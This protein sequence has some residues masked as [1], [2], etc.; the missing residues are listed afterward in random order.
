[1]PKQV[2]ARD[3]ILSCRDA[4]DDVIVRLKGLNTSTED[5]FLA[6]GEKLQPVY[7]K[8]E[9][10]KSLALSLVSSITGEQ[11]EGIVENLKGFIA[12][13]YKNIGDINSDFE[14]NTHMLRDIDSFIGN[15]YKPIN[16]F[17]KITKT[18]RILSISTKIES[19]KIENNM[20]GFFNI[21]GDVERL[22]TDINSR[23]AEIKSD[24][25]DLMTSLSESLSVLESAGKNC[26]GKLEEIIKKTQATIDTVY[27]KNR[28]TLTSAQRL[29]DSLVSIWDNIGELIL[30]LQFHDITRQQIEH[31]VDALKSLIEKIHKTLQEKDAVDVDKGLG[32]E[33][34]V[35]CGLEIEQ[36]F[37]AERKFI[38]AITDI[39]DNFKMISDN[40]TKVYKEAKKI[41]G[42]DSSNSTLFF[43]R[44]ESGVINISSSLRENINMINDFLSSRDKVLS[45]IAN[46]SKFIEDVE[47]INASIELIAVNAR[48]KAAHTGE[49]GAPLGVI[50]EAIQRLSSDARIK[51][52]EISWQIN[53]IETHIN[54]IS[55][56]LNG[57]IGEIFK[58]T[59]V[60]F[61]KMTR[62]TSDLMDTN[63][64]IVSLVNNIEE[65]TH[66]LG[67]TIIDV[68]DG[69]D[70]QYK[71]E[72]EI[73][74]SLALL[75]GIM[76]NIEDVIP[77]GDMEKRLSK[78]ERLHDRYTMQ[79]ERRVHSKYI[80]KSPV[81]DEVYKIKEDGLGDNV[82]LF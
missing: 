62:L 71:F 53:N 48:I 79:S 77:Q 57:E 50:S 46:M 51:K 20:D 59:D 25:N 10:I 41:A 56:D 5:K 55:L 81:P 37:D 43:S 61:E 21:A 24:T 58:N 66:I 74:Q 12:G 31:V 82:E 63:N 38:N 22:A 64:K 40:I 68:I 1:M 6:I 14:K 52:D 23:F 75:K 8:V 28:N 45:T 54:K 16:S 72:N 13:V 69:I 80:K 18:L 73:E 42:I 35:V 47:E 44:I 65:E 33:I 34:Y 76:K 70:V 17:K 49:I 7:Q 60:M 3:C 32:E 67:E 11:I 78:L 36:I 19:S 2:D 15:I 26:R 39:I 27:E 30:S 29:T 9:D 4:I